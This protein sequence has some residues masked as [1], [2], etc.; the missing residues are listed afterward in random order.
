MRQILIDWADEAWGGNVHLA[1]NG[2]WV[3]AEP[4]EADQ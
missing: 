3:G 4:Q 2:S 1:S